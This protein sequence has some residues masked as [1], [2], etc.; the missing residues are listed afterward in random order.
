[1]LL[2]RDHVSKDINLFGDSKFMTQHQMTRT[3]LWEFRGDV[4]AVRCMS[5]CG[6]LGRLGKALNAMLVR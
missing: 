3:G 1:M 2:E 6:D 5:Q 4:E